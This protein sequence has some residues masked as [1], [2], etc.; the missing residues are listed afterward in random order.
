MQRGAE[1]SGFSWVITRVNAAQH[2][3]RAVASVSDPIGAFIHHACSA[4][5]RCTRLTGD[6]KPATGAKTHTARL[7][8]NKH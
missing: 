2:T 4:P 8:A 3:A 1:M 5:D 6:K 7:S